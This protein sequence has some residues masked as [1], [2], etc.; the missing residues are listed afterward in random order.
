[1]FDPTRA[2]RQRPVPCRG[3]LRGSGLF[4]GGSRGGG[5]VRRRGGR[6]C[7][8][9]RQPH[10]LPG[11]PGH[12]LRDLDHAAGRHGGQPDR[13]SAGHRD[14]QHPDHG[15]RHLHTG[16][17]ARGRAARLL[18]PAQDADRLPELAVP[19]QLHADAAV[20]HVGGEGEPHLHL[21]VG[22]VAVPEHRSGSQTLAANIQLDGTTISANVPVII[23]NAVPGSFPSPIQNNGLLPIF[24]KTTF[25]FTVA[26]LGDGPSGST[27]TKAVATMVN[28]WN[29]D[30]LMYLGDVYQRGM[31][32]EFMNFYN[33]IYGSDAGKTISTIGNHEYKQ[34][35]DGS[36]YFWYWNFPNGSPTKPAGGQP[37]G[38]TGGGSWYSLDVGGPSENAWH[39]I[40]LNSNVPMTINPPTPQ[41]Q[42]LQQDLA[43]DLAARPEEHASVLAGLL[44]RR[45]VLGHQ[46]Q[47][48]LDVD[49][50]EPALPV[51]RRHHHQRPLPRLRALAAAQQLRRGRPPRTRASPSSWSAPAATCSPRPGT[52]TTPA[53]RQREHPLGRTQADALR[54]SCGLPVLGVEPADHVRLRHHHLP[55]DPGFL[56]PH[57]P[58]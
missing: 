7:R 47:T 49:V 37:G 38:G 8:H 51:R 23:S 24:S 22:H 4:G 25:P 28:S 9:L 17:A 35:T 32:D 18:R 52:P 21:D 12:G 5:V 46:P 50:L 30:M 29:P 40:S 6:A 36:G 15:D 57:R 19:G 41:G 13:W 3:E 48:A 58:L 43:A 53:R 56:G 26:A 54:G 27:Q 1:M 42:W 34:L 16:V 31:P 14:R 2:N 44:A 20:R 39:L 10:R 45:A 11:H 55:L 33:P